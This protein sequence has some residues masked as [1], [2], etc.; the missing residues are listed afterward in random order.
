MGLTCLAGGAGGAAQLLH[1]ACEP[2]SS[3]GKSSIEPGDGPISIPNLQ[4]PLSSLT[5]SPFEDGTS[6]LPIR[7]GGRRIPSCH[8]FS[9]R[10]SF[11]VYQPAFLHFT[12]NICIL[13]NGD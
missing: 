6:A 11:S 10:E 5:Q 4:A 1:V 8:L 7:A 12:V 2:S 3:T 13:L 9:S